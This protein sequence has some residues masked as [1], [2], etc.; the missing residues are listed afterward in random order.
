M[1]SDEPKPPAWTVGDVIRVPEDAY[2]FGSGSL[3]MYVAEV[4]SRGP[5]QGAEWAELRG[6]ELNPD[7]AL[8]ARERYAF[9][10]VDRATV[11]PV[12]SL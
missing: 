8:R 9:V 5:F 6:R 4:L 7:G 12:P 11:V 3:S 1:P 2:R 10:R